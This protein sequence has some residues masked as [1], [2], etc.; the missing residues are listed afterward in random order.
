MKTKIVDNHNQN[1][2]LALSPSL[3]ITNITRNIICIR[4]TNHMIIAKHKQKGAIAWR[5]L[6]AAKRYPCADCLA[7]CSRHQVLGCIQ[8]H[9]SRGYHLAGYTS[10]VD[11]LDNPIAWRPLLCCQAL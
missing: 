2:K 3:G 8:T 10:P 1:P 11:I 4:V 7:E 5:C 9:C 6:S